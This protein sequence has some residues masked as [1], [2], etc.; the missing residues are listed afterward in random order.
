MPK[1]F[2]VTTSMLCSN[3]GHK[4]VCLDSSLELFISM[5]LLG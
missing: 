1:I 2:P 5:A 3:L 4:L